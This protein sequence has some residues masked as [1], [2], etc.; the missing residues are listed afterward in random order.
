[1][2]FRRRPDRSAFDKRGRGHGLAQVGLALADVVGPANT[3]PHDGPGIPGDVGD[4]R[5]APTELGVMI[6]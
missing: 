3:P 1:M 6:G 4:G 5:V 2:A